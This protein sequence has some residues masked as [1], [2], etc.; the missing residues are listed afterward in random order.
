MERPGAVAI[1]A[2]AAF[3]SAHSSGRARVGLFSSS[4]VSERASWSWFGINYFLRWE[5]KAQGPQ[6]TLTTVCHGT[7][8]QFYDFCHTVDDDDYDDASSSSFSERLSC[9]LFGINN[10]MRGVGK[11]RGPQSVCVAT[12]G[13]H[14]ASRDWSCHVRIHWQDG[15]Y[16]IK[17]CDASRR[18]TPLRRTALAS[19]RRR[20]RSGG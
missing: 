10:F 1:V 17:P 20:R 8:C 9:S 18:A 11:A 7:P 14:P 3:H 6:S 5:G 2:N 16:C 19:R 12:S 15:T 4:Y 13:D